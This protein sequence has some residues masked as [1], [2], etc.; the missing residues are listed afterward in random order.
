MEVKRIIAA[1][2]AFLFSLPESG[3]SHVSVAF[4][5]WVDCLHS[6]DLTEELEDLDCED[7]PV[8]LAQL[9]DQTHFVRVENFQLKVR[10]SDLFITCVSMDSSD[11]LESRLPEHLLDSAASET[12]APV[13]CPV[14]GSGRLRE[15]EEWTAVSKVDAGH[16]ETLQEH[17][18]DHCD[19]T[20]WT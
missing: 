16:E 19:H 17:R 5:G 6:D 2:R 13:M 8:P 9:P 7:D 1:S 4:P 12:I 20:F 3:T 14:C 18:C 10:C 11:T 15:L